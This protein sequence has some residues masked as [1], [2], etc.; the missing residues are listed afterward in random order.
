[1][2]KSAIQ[3]TALASIYLL[4]SLIFARSAAAIAPPQPA[5]STSTAPSY[6][7]KDL[8]GWTVQIHLELLEP[9][10]R[11]ATEQALQLLT[12]QLNEICRVVPS[13]AVDRLQ[14][15]T[16][17]FSP[18]YP[19]IPPGAE[20]HP[21]GDWLR[22]NGRDPAMARGVEFTNIRIFAAET[23]RMPNFALHE[24]AHAYHHRELPD[25]FQNEP[26]QSAFEKA[27]ASGG[28]DRVERQD[29]EGNKRFDRAYALTNPQEYFAETTEA[30]FTRN[31][32][33]PFDHK[34]L[35][36]HDP[37]VC[38]LLTKLWGVQPSP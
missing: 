19:G 11:P 17:W 2:S 38:Q 28:Y 24:L 12:L 21:S 3:T 1:M 30:F 37:E 15:V 18:Q 26:L 23:R 27:K 4:A 33:F 36:Q 9:E 10:T 14:N 25:G 34:E 35:Q 16:L 22:A 6:A 13:A 29:S 20:Y 32:F 5:E 8:S 31:D 7:A